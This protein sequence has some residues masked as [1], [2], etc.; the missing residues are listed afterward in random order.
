MSAH[1]LLT[2]DTNPPA[3]PLMAINAGATVT[4]DRVVSV[5]LSSDSVDVSQMQIW[6][7]LDASANPLFQPTQAASALTAFASETFLT[8]SPGSGTKTLYAVLADD[9]GNQTLPFTGAILLDLD[10]PT[11]SVTTAPDRSRISKQ[12][13]F[14]SSTFSWQPSVD[15]VQYQVRVVPTSGSPV[16]AGVALGSSGGS[17]NVAGGA[18]S[19]STF[20]TTTV[21]GADL[22][23]ASPGDA[24][25]ICKVFVKDATGKWSA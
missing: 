16:S 11:V 17:V 15:V 21:T 25:K 19:A 3:R 1:L 20:V 12:S 18:V 9:V 4:A 5:R 6:G 14:D 2:L 10:S 24:T 23:A 22:A 13:G 8:L 7:D